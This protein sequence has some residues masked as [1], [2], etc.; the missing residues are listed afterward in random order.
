MADTTRRIRIVLQGLA[1]PVTING[2]PYDSVMPPVTLTDE[3]VANVLTYVRN[4]WGN[5]GEAVTVGF[6][7]HLSVILR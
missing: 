1:G 4:S 6:Q 2:A 5:T 3:Q 7:E